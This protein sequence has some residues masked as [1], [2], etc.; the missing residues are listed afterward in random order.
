[1]ANG[2]PISRGVRSNGLDHHV[3]EWP[4]A[5]DAAPIAILL[6]GFMDAGAT[7]DLV[8]P[9]LASAG[10][11]VIAPD[12]RGF[13]DAPR[14]PPGSYYHF[15]E[16]IADVAGIADEL[17]PSAPLFVVGHSMGGTAASLYAG[18]FPD[19]VRKLAILEGFG[20]PDNSPEVSPDRM[21]RWIDEE[22]KFRDAPHRSMSREEAVR[23]LCERHSLIEK[24]IVATRVPHLTKPVEH[25]RVVWKF[26]PMHRC[27]SPFPFYASMYRA[28]AARVTCPV[29][30][31]GGG[32]DGFHPPDE[33]D[34]IACFGDVKRATLAGAGHMMHW[35]RPNELS[36]LLVEFWRS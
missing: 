22:K 18:A 6:H 7:W 14:A 33:D 10:L 29:L 36:S 5:S 1:M 13:G 3:L 32:D 31:I 27:T 8:A 30:A 20:P 2:N 12:L 24:S 28:F 4:A 34:R 26:D 9:H 17:S 11:R 35:T 23:R 21:R 15:P 19:R 25:D 16:Y